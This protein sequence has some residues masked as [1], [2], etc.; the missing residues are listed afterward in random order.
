MSVLREESR[1]RHPGDE[2]NNSVVRG[3]TKDILWCFEKGQ[4]MV[5]LR[6]GWISWVPFVNR[7]GNGRG[8]LCENRWQIQKW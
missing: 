7:Q 6:S 3:G 5:S 8:A 4:K 1:G 2:G